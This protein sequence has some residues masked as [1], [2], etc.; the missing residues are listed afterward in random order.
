LLKPV[1]QFGKSVTELLDQLKEYEP[2]TR[3]RARRELRDRP[4]AQ[5]VAAVKAWV[6]K[7][8]VND[9]Q[10][11]QRL[12]EAL[13]VLQ[14]HHAV[15]G[16]LLTRVLR[17][18]KGEARAAATR[19][20]A[21]EWERIPNAMALVKP[22]LADEFPRTRLEA[23]RALSF[24]PG[25]ESL[26][27]LLATQNLPRDYWLDYTWRATLTALGQSADDVLGPLA[28]QG[29]RRGGRGTRA[30]Q[31]AAEEAFQR[32]RPGNTLSASERQVAYG[33]V[34]QARGS[35]ES[36]KAIFN[37]LCNSCHKVGDVGIVFGP[38]L[39]TSA[40]RL[41]RAQLVESILDPNAQLA[42]E[43]LTTQLE[44]KDD[45]VLSGFVSAEDERTVTL[46]M[47]GGLTR[48]FAKSDLLAR[49]ILKVSSM[50]EG[51][52]ATMTAGELADLVEFIS[53]LRTGGN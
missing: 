3:Y 31:T 5:V 22:S 53:S 40:G 44:T 39:A 21:D 7:L 14:G 9:P 46:R 11:D 12:C 6:A 17:A 1:T 15:D 28:G 49:Q 48:Q 36:G 52:G 42:P 10:Y 4:T 45:D 37:R 51:F 27:T 2:R 43:Y 20:L 23:V 13:W 41:T 18:K 50:P 34:A 38:D 47:A 26:D 8:D 30:A 25:K 16:E 24:A 19:V 35:A 29:G 32:L 33:T